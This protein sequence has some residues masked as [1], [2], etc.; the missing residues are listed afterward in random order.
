LQAQTAQAPDIG[1]KGGGEKALCP[2]AVSMA[3]IALELIRR[4]TRGHDKL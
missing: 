4:K 3:G 1:A 2:G